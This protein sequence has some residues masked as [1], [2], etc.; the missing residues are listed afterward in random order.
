MLCLLMFSM[1]KD[2][3]G[4]I[5]CRNSHG[6]VHILQLA[7]SSSTAQTNNQCFDTLIL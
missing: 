5:S 6:P 2:C 3:I 4:K 1:E 7:H